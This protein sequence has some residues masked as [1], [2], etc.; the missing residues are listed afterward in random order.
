[1]PSTIPLPEG[2]RII[3]ATEAIRRIQERDHYTPRGAGSFKADTVILALIRSG[4]VTV[5][6]SP[7]NQLLFWPNDLQSGKP[8]DPSNPQHR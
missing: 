2:A 6:L 5:A 7:D 3:D 4:A 1:M 8:F